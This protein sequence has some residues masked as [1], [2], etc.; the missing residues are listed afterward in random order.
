MNDRGR[1]AQFG[2]GQPLK[3]LAGTIERVTFHCL[4]TGFCVLKV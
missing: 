3:A 4:E 2:R 1:S